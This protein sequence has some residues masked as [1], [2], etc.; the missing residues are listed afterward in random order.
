MLDS[1]R[2]ELLNLNLRNNLIKLREFTARGLTIHEAASEEVYQKL[3]EESKKC[4]FLSN[5]SNEPNPRGTFCFKTNY[6]EKELERRL[7]RTYSEAKSFIDE[8]G[9]STLYLT[10]GALKWYEE[11]SSSIEILSPL[12]L[13]PVRLERLVQKG[14]TTFEL[15]YNDES[16]E[17]NYTL[18]RKLDVDFGIKLPSFDE[19]SSISAYFDSIRESVKN[20][21]RWDIL[22]NEVRI[23]LFSFLKLMM[24]HDLDDANWSENSKPSE[25]VL[26]KNLLDN[27]GNL[28]T[29][30]EQQEVTENF[31]LD[32]IPLSSIDHILDADSS[33]AEAIERVFKNQ[34]LVIKGPPGTGKSQTIANIIA[35]CI[36][37]GKTVLFVSE[38]LAALKVVKNRLEKTGLGAACLELHSNRANRREILENISRTLHKKAEFNVR[39]N[40]ELLKLDESRQCLN[41]YYSSLLAPINSS[42][43]S[44]FHAIGEILSIRQSFP[45]V[46]FL[47]A[48]NIKWTRDDINLRDERIKSTCNFIAEH[49]HPHDLPFWGISKLQIGL[50]EEDNIKAY[51][52]DV[53]KSLAQLAESS[54]RISNKLN[55]PHAANL[56]ELKQL[57]NTAKALLSNPGIS[58]INLD[59]NEREI[60][61]HEIRDFFETGRKFHELASQY[62]ALLLP[63]AHSQNFQR[64]KLIYETKGKSWFRF[65]Y[66]D[67]RKS[68]KQLFNVLKTTP[69]SIAE[70]IELTHVLVEKS[71]LVEKAKRMRSLAKQLFTGGENWDFE[72]DEKWLKKSASVEYIFE[73]KTQQNSEN[74][75]QKILERLD[76]PKNT[77]SQE[78]FE[79]ES[80][81]TDFECNLHKLVSALAYEVPFHEQFFGD[82]TRLS[83]MEMRI[84]DMSKRI[85][86][87]TISCRWN[88]YKKELKELGCDK[89]V[90]NLLKSEPKN[91]ISIY[92]SWRYSIMTA[93]LDEAIKSRPSLERFDLSS[94]AEVFRKTD[95]YMIEEYNRLKI[96]HEHLGRIPR[97]NALGEPMS[98][99][100]NEISKQRR[101][102]P[103]RK[104][105]EQAGEMIVKIKPVFMMSPLSVAD[106]LKPD[107][108]QFDYVIFDEASQVKPVEAFG[109]LLRASRAVVVGDDK[110]L[111]P[112]NFF[113]QITDSEETDEEDASVIPDLESILDL[114][115]T[116]NA[117]QTMLKWH[118]RSKHES[119]I[120][121]SNKHFYENKLINLPSV[122]AQS[123]D[124]GLQFRHL[125]ETNYAAGKNEKEA[126]HIITALIEHSRTYPNPESHSIGIVAFGTK[127]KDC[128]E[129]L[130]MRVRKSDPNFDKY[131]GAAENAQEPFFVKNLE[132]VQGDE[133]DVI[134]VSI[135]YG[136]NTEG[137]LYKRFGPINQ[138]G[139]ER[140]LN[141]LFTRARLKCVLFSNFTAGDLLIE[142]TDSLG[143]SVFKAFLD[144]AQNR[145]FN[146]PKITNKPTDSPFE[147]S[148][149]AILER[150]GYE[151]HTQIGSAGYFVDLAIPDPHQKGR[152]L[153]GIEC[154]GATYHSSKSARERDRLRQSVLE[155]LGWNIYRIWS[156]D[157]FRQPSIELRKLLDYIN[158]LERG[159]TKPE[160]NSQ[161]LLSKPV[162]ERK[163]DDASNTWKERYQQASLDTFGIYNDL[164]LVEDYELINIVSQL[165]EIESP[166]HKDY[167]KTVITQ[168]MGIARIGNRI[169]NRFN[170]VFDMGQKRDKWVIKNK[171]IWR[172]NQKIEKVRDRRYLPDKFRQIE[173]VA[174]EEI[175]F[176]L[177]EIVIE[178]GAIDRLE[179]MRAVISNI[180]GGN[181]LTDGIRQ[182]V[183]KEVNQLILN[184]MFLIVDGL[185]R[186]NK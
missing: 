167:A 69:S 181:R 128:I 136:K 186:L 17:P 169:E 55:L 120:A 183:E 110:Q 19:N 160:E 150:E 104:L 81:V 143:L 151:V 28:S 65:I 68:K 126:E 22:H 159:I 111:P 106:F 98:V 173:W 116:R 131:L 86:L 118:Y 112:S 20:K 43:I 49:G 15:K 147:D 46:S 53:K 78:T 91:S 133:R 175:Q 56:K 90:E 12:L 161:V 83:E 82:G 101:H 170:E 80:K 171:F 75:N 132:N 174:P 61:Q 145:T 18:E 115:V 70:Q 146:I 31:E 141:V 156:T 23:N 109:A 57:L 67:F 129:N 100:R 44:P 3:I 58:G 153:L 103:L 73:L 99:L 114:F 36:R 125:P 180:N 135:C 5:E 155:G 163:V 157:W 25:N 39:D 72:N 127:Q 42:E 168:K 11:D 172:H 24:Y 35:S 95:R 6:S 117:K 48:T 89:V 164:H 30:R 158:A 108:I 130:L 105:L 2:K 182:I 166:V 38:K 79:L 94:N 152:Y 123:D 96:Q 1:L 84:I 45:E 63:G 47:G 10:L 137:R 139:G 144:Y 154:D 4:I 93:L 52:S 185:I 165:L 33:Q 102:L 59:F 179:L 7:F 177:K 76:I 113:G 64:V 37:K 74:V 92:A 26:I 140:R 16:I 97:F 77:F 13:I 71:E 88:T 121:V 122:F 62:D 124:L 176:A 40:G 32:N 107:K 9:I 29:G 119:L 149:K 178:A 142:A 87:L 51:I 54:V 14:E 27:F 184:Q 60:T 8:K 50:I 34:Y 21:K 138:K 162:L 41:N 85:E 148:V 134:F 66:A